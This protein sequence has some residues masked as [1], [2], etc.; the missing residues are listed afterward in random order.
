MARVENMV[1]QAGGVVKPITKVYVSDTGMRVIFQLMINL[2]TSV[3]LPRSRVN[4][5]SWISMP[6]MAVGLLPERIFILKG[7]SMS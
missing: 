1:Y 6:A 7:T 3:S 4:T 2:A 5:V